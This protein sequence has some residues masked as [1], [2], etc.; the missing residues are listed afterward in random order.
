MVLA[1][2]IL[3]YEAYIPPGQKSC[4]Q[5]ENALVGLILIAIIKH[6]PE[7]LPA[8]YCCTPK[9]STLHVSVVKIDMSVCG[10]VYH[11]LWLVGVGQRRDHPYDVEIIEGG[12]GG[13]RT[14]QDGR[15]TSGHLNTALTHRHFQ[16]THTH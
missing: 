7:L 2:K 15:L 3:S 4:M 16:R 12:A 11:L 9:Y 6:F 1:E 13:E 5:T 8:E 14:G 10:L